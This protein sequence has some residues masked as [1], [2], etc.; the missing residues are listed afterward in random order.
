MALDPVDEQNSEKIEAV[1][2]GE[3]VLNCK[4]KSNFEQ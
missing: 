3:H 4:D 1:N 2:G